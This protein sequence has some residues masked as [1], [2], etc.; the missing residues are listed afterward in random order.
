MPKQVS[1]QIMECME[2]NAFGRVRT[3]E[4]IATTMFFKVFRFACA[5]GR[6][7][8]HTSKL[9]PKSILKSTQNRCENDAP[10]SDAKTIEHL[11]KMDPK[12]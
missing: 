7:T 8:E 1:K 3:C 4:F 11:A 10:K 6:G 9:R 12:R 5:N 2:N